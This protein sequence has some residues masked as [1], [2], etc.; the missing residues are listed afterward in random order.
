[1][2]DVTLSLI[3]VNIKQIGED[4]VTIEVAFD[5]FNP[6]KNTMVLETIQYDLIANG[7]RLTQSSI[8]ER[9]QG[10]VSGTGHTYYA[11]SNLPLTLK[12]TVQLRKT[13]LFAPIW[14]NLQSNDVHWRI[15]GNYVVTD[16][17][18]LGGQEKSFDFAL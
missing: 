15:K 7:I 12:D 6:N 16:P 1:M 4:N 10:V 2:K 18:R 17:V 5:V 13:E 11:V 9:L 3:S 8:G 14:S